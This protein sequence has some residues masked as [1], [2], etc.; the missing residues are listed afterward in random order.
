[1]DV[2]KDEAEVANREQDPH[3][4]E[5]DLTVSGADVRKCLDEDNLDDPDSGERPA[6]PTDPRLDPE[7]GWRR[8]DGG[9]H[10]EAVLTGA[11]WMN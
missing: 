4:R 11:S 1:M 5:D 2:M 8:L 6:H 7:R 9:K 3:D 10:S